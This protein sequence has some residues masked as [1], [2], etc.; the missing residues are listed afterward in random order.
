[1]KRQPTDGRYVLVDVPRYPLVYQTFGLDPQDPSL[2]SEGREG[3]YQPTRVVANRESGRIL[4]EEWRPTCLGGPNDWTIVNS[5]FDSALVKRIVADLK[6][7]TFALAYGSSKMTVAQYLGVDV[8]RTQGMASAIAPPVIQVHDALLFDWSDPKAAA[9]LADEIKRSVTI[10]IHRSNIAITPKE[11]TTMPP[12]DFYENDNGTRTFYKVVGAA[13]HEPG[14]E[15]RDRIL[16]SI[17]VRD[18]VADPRSLRVRLQ[19]M[20]A[21][22]RSYATCREYAISD[23]GPEVVSLCYLPV[24]VTL[25]HQRLREFLTRHSVT[26]TG[27]DSP[28]TENQE[29]P[30]ND[31]T[32]QALGYVPTKSTNADTIEAIE[33]R[34]ATVQELIDTAERADEPNISDLADLKMVE[35]GLEANLESYRKAARTEAEKAEEKNAETRRIAIGRLNAA[36]QIVDESDVSGNSTLVAEVYAS[37]VQVQYLVPKPVETE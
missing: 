8:E 30:V 33:K 18:G 34:L 26:A 10:N 25:D 32:K 11:E 20:P 16:A 29:H 3:D 21:G 6:R 4:L 24:N 28:A 1:M 22:R 36:Q 31:N 17:V 5:F 37:L 7:D 27:A 9:R 15:P 14:R 19:T 13:R 35:A 12:R 2:T 23:L